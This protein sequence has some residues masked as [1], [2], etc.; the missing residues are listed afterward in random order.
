M[1]WLKV[2]GRGRTQRIV[3]DSSNLISCKS[4]NSAPPVQLLMLSSDGCLTWLTSRSTWDG[5]FV[6]IYTASRKTCSGT[7]VAISSHFDV[8]VSGAFGLAGELCIEHAQCRSPLKFK[9]NNCP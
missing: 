9:Q 3:V 7:M 5:M 1:F 4:M 8:G 6:P 2:I